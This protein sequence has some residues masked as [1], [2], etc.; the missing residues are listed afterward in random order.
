VTRKTKQET[1]L[2]FAKSQKSTQ[3]KSSPSQGLLEKTS[4][5]MKFKPECKHLWNFVFKKNKKR[6]C[7]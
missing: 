2:G 1:G 3:D 7:T 6:K 4:E 5:W